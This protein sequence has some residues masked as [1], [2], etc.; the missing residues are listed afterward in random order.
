VGAAGRTGPPHRHLRRVTLQ[1]AARYAQ[2]WEGRNIGLADWGAL[3]CVHGQRWDGL[4]GW[5]IT[6]ARLRTVSPTATLAGTG[7]CVVR[8][9]QPCPRLGACQN[10]VCV[11]LEVVV[12]VVPV[13]LVSGPE[14]RPARGLV[15]RM[16]S[17][18]VWG[19]EVFEWEVMVGTVGL[20]VVLGGIDEAFPSVY[21]D[22]LLANHLP[23]QRRA[24]VVP[25]SLPRDLVRPV[26]ENAHRTPSQRRTG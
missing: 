13:G 8:G 24:L 21:Q 10:R 4:G 11:L 19:E 22:R 14:A 26:H 20:P 15:R 3:E 12:F 5:R 6:L 18:L 17:T 1:L 23:L 9:E 16:S 25:L 2:V 7:W